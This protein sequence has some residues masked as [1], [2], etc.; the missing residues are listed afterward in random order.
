MGPAQTDLAQDYM[1]LNDSDFSPIVNDELYNRIADLSQNC[2]R[3]AAYGV[4][5]SEGD[6][7][8][9]IHMNSGTEPGDQ[10]ADQDR[11]RPG[12]RDR[13]L[14]QHVRGR[15]AESVCYWVFVKFTS[16]HVVEF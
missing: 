2:D 9:D 10:H 3:I 12:R 1:G 7:I 15:S 6:G 13:V 8:H 5:Y 4:T 14:L 11:D 16:Q